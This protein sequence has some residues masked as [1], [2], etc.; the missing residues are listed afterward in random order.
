[1]SVTFLVRLVRDDMVAET[2]DSDI[3]ILQLT[4]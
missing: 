4:T 3:D 1:M 2:T